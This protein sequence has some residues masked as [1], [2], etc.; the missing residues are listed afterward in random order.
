MP[1]EMPTMVL[2]EHLTT[3]IVVWRFSVSCTDR[4]EVSELCSKSACYKKDETTKRTRNY[5][6]SQA[7]SRGRVQ[8]WNR[9]YWLLSSEMMLQ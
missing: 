9:I 8:D 2:A 6:G 7:D 5:H 3:T 4:Q 1:Q